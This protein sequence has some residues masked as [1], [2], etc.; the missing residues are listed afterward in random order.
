M[1][2]VD[3]DGHDAGVVYSEMQ[4]RENSAESRYGLVAN[5]ALCA[6]VWWSAVPFM[7]VSGSGLAAVISGF[8]VMYRW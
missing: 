5:L 6:V 1:H 2:H 4:G 7:A 3:G 8:M